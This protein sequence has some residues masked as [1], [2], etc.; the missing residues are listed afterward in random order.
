MNE[1]CQGGDCLIRFSDWLLFTVGRVTAVVLTKKGVTGFN[2][3]FSHDVKTLYTG[4]KVSVTY[5]FSGIT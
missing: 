4:Q 2:R 1:C 3:V 5:N